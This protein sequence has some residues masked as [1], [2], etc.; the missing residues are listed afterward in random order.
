M[1]FTL[2]FLRHKRNSNG[3]E[4]KNRK[5]YAAL[6]KDLTSSPQ[7]GEQIHRAL[8]NYL[9]AKIDQTAGTITFADVKAK[10][11]QNQRETTL[12]N[13]LKQ[14]MEECEALRYAGGE[15]SPG[16]TTRLQ[17]TLIAL[18]SKLEERIW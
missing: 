11:T 17:D 5:A 16:Y 10:I 3:T 9:A 18:T 2:S 15:D 4:R 7:S 13:E 6:K 12:L 8:Q 1:G 14:I